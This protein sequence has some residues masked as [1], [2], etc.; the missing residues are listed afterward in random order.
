[1]GGIRKEQLEPMSIPP[2][3]SRAFVA[4]PGFPTDQVL[5]S[6]YMVTVDAQAIS[7]TMEL[8]DATLVKGRT[9]LIVKSD[10]GGSLLTIRSIVPGQTIG[11]QASRII[12]GQGASVRVTSDGANYWVG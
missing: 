4:T 9:F 11:G 10:A 12:T 3:A 7:A 2:I 8:M 1:M 5:N 6:D